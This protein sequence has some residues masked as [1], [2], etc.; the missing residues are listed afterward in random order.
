MKYRIECSSDAL[1]CVAANVFS[2]LAVRR[3]AVEWEPCGDGAILYYEDRQVLV[4]YERLGRAAM[5]I[6]NSRVAEAEQEFV[7]RSS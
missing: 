6:S 2:P 3:E 5:L 4:T 7:R 1:Q